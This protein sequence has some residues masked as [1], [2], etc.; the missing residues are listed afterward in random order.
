[1]D[2]TSCYG[3]GRANYT[4]QQCLRRGRSSN[5]SNVFIYLLEG[6]LKTGEFCSAKWPCC[7]IQDSRV[8]HTIWH[9]DHVSR[10]YI[11]WRS[12]DIFSSATYSK[13]YWQS[14]T[15]VSIPCAR[16]F[17][18]F[19]R[20]LFKVAYQG[21]HL[22]YPPKALEA[23]YGCVDPGSKPSSSAL[24]SRLHLLSGISVTATL[25]CCCSSSST[26]KSRYRHSE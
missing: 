3:Y 16:L 4:R 9:H 5:K 6:M 2:I 7:R 26:E 14:V 25:Y 1:M 8:N 23:D 13:G 12:V 22:G 19:R 10:C 15:L 18:L 21:H 11:V 24:I 17:I 20:L